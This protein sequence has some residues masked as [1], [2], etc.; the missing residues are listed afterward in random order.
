MA[1]TN[2]RQKLL[3]QERASY[4]ILSPRSSKKRGRAPTA[5]DRE[6]VEKILMT[7]TEP[8]ND[9]YSLLTPE[10]SANSYLVY[11]RLRTEAPV[12]WSPGLRGWLITRY[13]IFGLLYMIK[14]FP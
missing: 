1:E 7:T 12:Y 6:E 10:A 4:R 11:Q 13:R 8:E 9:Q 14:D 2:K 5:T 3:D